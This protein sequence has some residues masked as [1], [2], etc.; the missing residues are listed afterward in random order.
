MKRLLII[1]SLAAIVA[2]PFA[3]RP[4]RPEAGRAADTLVV[5]TPNNEAIR[6]EFGI[7]FESWYQ[8][9]TGRSIAIDWRVLGGTSEIARYLEGE[10]VASFRNYWTGGLGRPWS[11]AVEQGFQRDPLSGEA[12]PQEAEARE[13]FL[14][15]DVGCGIDVFFGGG[16]YD[17]D[18]QALAGRLVPSGVVSR[19]PDW[20]NDG[21]IALEFDG[22]PYRD[23]QARWLGS[24]I[25]AYGIIYHRDA[26]RRLGI[27]REPS[28]WSDLADPRLFGQVALCDPTKSG[29]IATAFENVIQQEIHRQ[30]RDLEAARKDSG[31]PGSRPDDGAL[32]AR[33]VREG[34]M[35]G[36]RLLQEIG[37]NARYFTDASQKPPID[38]ADGDCA[39]GMCIDFYGNQQQEALRR[40]GDWGRV[41]FVSPPGGTAYSVDPVAI[42]RGARNRAAAE[43]F[44]DY[45]L[46]MEGQKLWA[47]KPG[48][49]GG[50][51]QFALRRL[52]IRRD[53]Y[54]HDEWKA[55]RSDPDAA[56]YA[57]ADP[58][59]YRAEWTEPLFR[60]M[61]FIIRVM[62]QD[63]HD[64][65]AGAWRAIL[66]AKGP[67][68]EEALAE[69]QD[70]SLV[71]YDRARGE[72]SAALGSKDQVD[73]VRLASRLA[74]EFRAR[75]ARAEKLAEGK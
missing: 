47:F 16:T 8:R 1:L 46:S 7:G 14:H 34:W 18:R 30:L 67:A 2:I 36:L 53:F 22:E 20:F 23:P 48:A 6:H 58:L 19:H 61:A 33:A 45:A 60:E 62:C 71:S 55:L 64:E 29:S 42:L 56:P 44:M 52:P 28:R 3:V 25:S 27:G 69:L 24:V 26:L 57:Q 12:S 70:L 11:L 9:T 21:V 59:V 43:A 54:A 51:R 4:K 39:A 74:A 41:G 17:F 35:A 31:A 38:V 13:A 32:E 15:S 73:E 75:Y 10:Y 72:I 40:R 5:V 37:A 65:L 63:T 50:P 49:P 66:R 68:R